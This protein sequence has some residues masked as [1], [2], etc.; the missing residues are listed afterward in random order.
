MG[1]TTPSS[2]PKELWHR[3]PKHFDRVAYRCVN[4]FVHSDVPEADRHL[5][6]NL[7]QDSTLCRVL[8]TLSPH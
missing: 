6:S 1:T 3:A 7:T 4:I 8:C 5:S 2:V